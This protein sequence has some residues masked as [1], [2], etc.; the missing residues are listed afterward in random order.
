MS[1]STIETP[2]LET[3]ADSLALIPDPAE[4]ARRL[5]VM[6]GSVAAGRLLLENIY[7]LR[8]P[9][10]V[11]GSAVIPL[12]APVPVFPRVRQGVP[13]EAF[14]LLLS[15][16]RERSTP[17]RRLI[18]QDD[19]APLRRDVAEAAGWAYDSSDVSYETDLKARSYSAAP[20][21]WEGDETLL[22]HPE[23]QGLL[24]A[25]GKPDLAFHG[26]FRDG[27]AVVALRVAEERP[28]VALGAYGPAKPGFGGVD[29]IGVHP[30]HR[31]RGLGTRLF[32]HLLARLAPAFD[33]HG[34]LTSVE[35]HA[36]RRIF[37]GAGSRHTATHL[38][39][40]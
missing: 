24:D 31:G 16:L 7:I 9:R 6:Q 25:L 37:Q 12:A 21:A 29:M 35:N 13:D 1:T 27:W 36:M 23:V 20:F 22:E 15:T 32:T 39:F 5:E 11:E 8:S 3:L 34:G 14:G 38:V 2:T 19:V 40:G 33:S 28:L 10:G 30:E 4:R 17:G 26:G 18:L